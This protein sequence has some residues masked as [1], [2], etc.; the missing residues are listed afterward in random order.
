MTPTDL[1][2]VQEATLQMAGVEGTGNS[3]LTGSAVK[4]TAGGK[5][6]LRRSDYE[7]HDGLIYTKN[8]NVVGA[9]R[10]SYRVA[11]VA[12]GISILS[13]VDPTGTLVP[14]SLPSGK[15]LFMVRTGTLTATQMVRRADFEN[16]LRLNTMRW[17]SFCLAF[18]GL[19]FLIEPASVA[20]QAVPVVGPCLNTLMVVGVCKAGLIGAAMTLSVVV[21]V[22]W[23][24][25]DLRVGGPAFLFT[26][27]G[28]VVMKKWVEQSERYGTIQ[29]R[30]VG[31][32][33]VEEEVEF[34]LDD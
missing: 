7:L 6:R 27:I 8:R 3:I 11:P 9:L 21:G 1:F 22:L 16:T 2:V 15:S 4:K 30:R 25:V 23:V 32:E 13:G 24:A 17:I 28:C 34:G 18:F 10:I 33:E 5:Q 14:Y 12:K 19:L 26:P 29:Y 31:L 20:C